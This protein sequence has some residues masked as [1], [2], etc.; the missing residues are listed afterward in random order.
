MMDA[1]NKR[2]DRWISAGVVD[3]NTAVRIRT[4]EESERSKEGFRRPMLLALGLGGVLLCAGLLLF[5]AAHWAELS[6]AWRFSLVLFLVGLFPVAGAV[7][8]QRFPALST[9]LYTIGT[10]C[11]GAGIFLT[12][13]IFNLQEHWPSG[14]LLWALGALVGWLLLRQWPQGVLL[15]LLVPAWL[16]G[17]WEVRTRGDIFRSPLVVEGMLLLSLTY[18]TARIGTEDS[19]VRRGLAWIGGIS[20]LPLAILA[21]FDRHEWIWSWPPPEVP[22]KMRVFG[23]IIGIGAPLL[24]AFVLRKKA[25]WI[26]ALSVFWVLV[27]GTFHSHGSTQVPPWN[28]YDDLGPYFWGGLGALGL[29]AWGLLERRRERI[30]LGVAGFA[31][32]VVIFYFSDVMDKLGR[33]TSLIGL[34]LIFLLGGWALEM[35]RRKLITSLSGGPQ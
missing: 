10:I 12:A 17:E 5:V 30:N 23:W 6:P 26:N 19:V 28:I 2:L 27:I 4:Y 31:L 22:V 20:L 24:L 14:I 29:I 1:L 11:V 13:Q 34:G 7:T 33:S 15:S 16:L 9:T 32:T 18:L 21:F 3:A 8:T 35:T 25:V